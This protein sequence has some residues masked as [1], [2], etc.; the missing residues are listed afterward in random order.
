MV[1][2]ELR[3]ERKIHMLSLFETCRNGKNI[4]AHREQ[5]LAFKKCNRK[6]QDTAK[7]KRSWENIVQFQC[8]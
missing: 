5:K 4:H 1:K 3:K 7:V 2:L 8:K 6:N